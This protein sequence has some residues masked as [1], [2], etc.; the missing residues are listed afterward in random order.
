MIKIMKDDK[1]ITAYLKIISEASSGKKEKHGSVKTSR[2]TT[3]FKN[4]LEKFA[5]D[6]EEKTKKLNEFIEIIKE[7]SQD[8]ETIDDFVEFIKR[9]CQA[10]P[11]SGDEGSTE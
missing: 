11:A 8:V 5:K 4:F 2:L 10:I 1:F 6:D 3:P 9:V 7:E